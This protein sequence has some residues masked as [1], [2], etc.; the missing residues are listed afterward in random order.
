M[1]PEV[2]QEPGSDWAPLTRAAL[3][4]GARGYLRSAEEW[5]QNLR[6][7][8]FPIC[9][10][11]GSFK[12][13]EKSRTAEISYGGLSFYICAENSIVGVR[14]DGSEW[15]DAPLFIGTAEDFLSN[16]KWVEY[17]PEITSA[18]R[19]YRTIA[20]VLTSFNL[21]C[22]QAIEVGAAVIMARKSTV[23]AP[24]ERITLDQWRY[25]KLDDPP[26]WDTR[27]GSRALWHNYHPRP[28]FN[29]ATG[30]AG[31]KLFA[32]HLAPGTPQQESETRESEEKCADYLLEQMRKQRQAGRPQAYAWAAFHVEVADLIRRNELPVKKEAAIEQIL[33]WFKTTQNQNPS[34]SAVS[35]KLTPYY[36]RFFKSDRKPYRA[37]LS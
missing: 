31:E 29:V 10:G 34:R 32:I 15:S 12:R 7:K 9:S 37:F 14:R 30:P 11:E 13:F 28:N 18:D 24:F 5:A 8:L 16:R 25:F 35:E 20:G 2:L 4:Y 27:M 6:G 21:D 23:L 19:A 3:C 22:M 33:T 1:T 17:H 36:E 26:E